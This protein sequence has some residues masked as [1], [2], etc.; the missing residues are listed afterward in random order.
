MATRLVPL[1]IPAGSPIYISK[2]RVISEPAPAR[3]LMNP[4]RIPVRTRMG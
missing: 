4:T 3:V 2:G 1:A